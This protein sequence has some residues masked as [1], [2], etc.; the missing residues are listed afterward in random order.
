MGYR[1]YIYEVD[2]VLVN[3]IR[4]CQTMDD[5][6]N[7]VST[8][9]PDAYEYY[10]EDDWC[11]KLYE[12]GKELFCF[13]KNYENAAEIHKHGTSLFVSAELNESF[14]R[15]NAIILEKEGLV[16]AIEWQKR[17]IVSIYEDLLKEK[18]DDK[19]DNRSQLDRMR[20][21]IEDHLQWWKPRFGDFCAYNLNKATDSIARSHLYEHTIFDLVRIY[22]TFD[23][24]NKYM[25]FLGW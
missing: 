23:W 19:F 4:T 13:G 8:D 9:R 21:H 20:E 14:S 17:K 7:V 18:S 15:E 16:N 12:L 5:L 11:V 25:I 22:K 10:D 2:K 1:Y 3:K 24:E 6:I